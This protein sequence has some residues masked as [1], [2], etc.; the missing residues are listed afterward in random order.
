MLS[1]KYLLGRFVELPSWSVPAGRLPD[2]TWRQAEASSCLTSTP[3]AGAAQQGHG[4]LCEFFS[5]NPDRLHNT[6]NKRLSV[7]FVISVTQ[8]CSQNRTTWCSITCTHSPSRW[9]TTPAFIL[10]ISHQHPVL[11]HLL[12]FIF[13]LE[14]SNHINFCSFFN[15]V[16][17]I[18][19]DLKIFKIHLIKSHFYEN[20]VSFVFRMEW[21]FSA[22]LTDI[23]RN[24]WRRSSTSPYNNIILIYISSA[25]TWN[26][27][28]EIFFL[29]WYVENMVIL[30]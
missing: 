16:I 11:C 23:K 24:M 20:A 26:G 7:W 28:K 8:R 10:K 5:K 15:P 21:W 27:T 17:T 30:N 29:F 1:F 2:Q 14:F 25:A 19:L 4:H 6:Q 9:E 3:A 22:Q 13:S 12:L 18:Y